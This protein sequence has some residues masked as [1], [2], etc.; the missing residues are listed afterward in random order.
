MITM[1]ITVVVKWSEI[2]STSLHSLNS[3]SDDN[4]PNDNS[5]L[6][7]R[8]CSHGPNSRYYERGKYSRYVGDVNVATHQA[9]VMDTGCV[10]L[11]CPN[12]VP[13]TNFGNRITQVSSKGILGVSFSHHIFKKKR[14]IMSWQ[15]SST[16]LANQTCNS[17]YQA[18]P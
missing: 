18:A 8:F 15:K 12:S 4:G 16:Y 9:H 10:N 13:S 6:A 1:G 11:S 2:D 5:G 14:K 3:K 7:K 17:T